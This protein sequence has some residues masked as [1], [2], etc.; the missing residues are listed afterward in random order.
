MVSLE[1]DVAIC[2]NHAFCSKGIRDIVYV[3]VETLDQT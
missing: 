1:G 3:E 2:R